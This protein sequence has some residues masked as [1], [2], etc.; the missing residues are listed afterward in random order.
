M[1]STLTLKG[2]FDSHNGKISLE[3]TF[4]SVFLLKAVVFECKG[5][6]YSQIG[7]KNI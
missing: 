4:L 2:Y 6:L 7:I 1:F 5:E 3:L